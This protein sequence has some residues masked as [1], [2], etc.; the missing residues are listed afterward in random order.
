MPRLTQDVFQGWRPR[1]KAPLLEVP[2]LRH[3]DVL[4]RRDL[5]QESMPGL[6][7]T[8]ML[9]D[10]KDPAVG[11]RQR[12]SHSALRIAARYAGGRPRVPRRV[13][14]DGD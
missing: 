8:V 5:P 6:S 7:I 4:D 2:P 3:C 10:H 1:S 11:R 14:L 12:E 13:Q 9:A